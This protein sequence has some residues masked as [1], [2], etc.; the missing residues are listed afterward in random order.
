[1][2]V[3]HTYLVSK[4]NMVLTHHHDTR[5]FS[6]PPSLSLSLF[7]LP[8]LHMYPH[9]GELGDHDPHKHEPGYVAEFRIVPKQ[10][11]DI[12][13][14]ISELHQELVGKTN[15]EVEYLFLSYARRQVKIK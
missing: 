11:R 4:N 7:L 5:S 15:A 3:C 14:R 10:N 1:M 8:P 13:E 12:E 6:F 9:S 2:H